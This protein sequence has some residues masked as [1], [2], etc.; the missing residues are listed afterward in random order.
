MRHIKIAIFLTTILS[1]L[2]GSLFIILDWDY[3]Y[4]FILLGLFTV[5][6]HY[7]IRIVMLALTKQ[8]TS[9]ITLLQPSLI[10]LVSVILFSKYGHFKFG[11]LPGLLIIPAFILNSILDLIKKNSNDLKL[12][13]ITILYAIIIIPLFGDFFYWS[14]RKYLPNEWYNRYNTEVGIAIKTPYGFDYKQTEE[15][16]IKAFDLRKSQNFYQAIQVYEEAIN[17]EPNNPRLYFD[18]AEC[19][20]K[21]NELELA[22]SYL[23]KAISIDSTWAGFYNNRGL[24]FYKLND[25]TRAIQDFQTAIRLDSTKSSIYVNM[26]LAYHD[27]HDFDNACV[28]IKKAENIGIDYLTG[29]AFKRIKKKYCK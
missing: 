14:P 6:I 10:V 19:H 25:A 15:L 24:I 2:I 9:F 13:F 16:S 18:I 5:F 12:T 22:I 26:A 8:N 11:D 7:S 28:A 20:A 17:I 23:S 3:G 4:I 27:L 21:V 29:K 1:I